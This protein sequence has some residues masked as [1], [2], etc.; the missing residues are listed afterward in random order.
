[1]SHD[2]RS[3]SRPLTTKDL[4][5]QYAFPEAPPDDLFYGLPAAERAY[6]ESGDSYQAYVRAGLVHGQRCP[7]NLA[8]Q[9]LQKPRVKAAVHKLQ[10]FFM[11][12]MQIHAEHVLGLLF[13][14]ATAD[15]MQLYA[16]N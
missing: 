5:P 9:Y 11:K 4:V 3:R 6:V 12:H 10:T 8:W 15:A 13:A 1:M 2:D 7:K 14:H 16:Q